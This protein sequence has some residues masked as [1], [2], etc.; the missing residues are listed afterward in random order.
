MAG[1]KKTV[2][3]NFLD[4]WSPLGLSIVGDVQDVFHKIIHSYENPMMLE[5]LSDKLLVIVAVV[6]SRAIC[7]ELLLLSD[8]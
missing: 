5:V 3:S 4:C 7:I 8:I 2:A 1:V 6:F